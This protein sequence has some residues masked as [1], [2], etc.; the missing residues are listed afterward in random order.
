MQARKDYNIFYSIFG[1]KTAVAML[2]RNMD[3]K[4]RNTLKMLQS[5][6][7]EIFSRD[8][9]LLLYFYRP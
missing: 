4:P 9:I 2:P 5:K 6:E 7:W 1:Q 8:A 3:L